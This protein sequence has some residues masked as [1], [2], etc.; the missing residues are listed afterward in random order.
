MKIAVLISGGVDSSVALRLLKDEGH[1][2]TAFYL[3][4][5]LED[6]L[7]Y[8]GECPWKE[9]LAYVRQICDEAKVPFEVINM[10]KE[11]WD[12]VVDYTIKEAKAGRTPN[13]DIFCNQRVKFGKFYDH[14]DLSY[15]KVATG[16]YAQV[17]SSAVSLQSSAE[18][19]ILK[20][21]PDTIK[22]Q[23][24]FLVH[25]DQKQLSRA[26]FPIGKYKKS[27]VRELANKYNLSNKD[28]KDSQGICF[29]GKVPF[30]EFIKHHLGEKPGDFVDIQSKKV[31]GQHDGYWFY[32][33]GQ[34]QGL[35]LSGGPW[36]VVDK[37]VKKN[38]VYLAQ[39]YEPELV[40]KENFE[41]S[42]LHWINEGLKI[43]DYGLSVKIRHGAAVHPCRLEVK[44]NKG[45]V[46][47]SEKV[48]GVAPGQ[49][50]VF[51]DGDVCLGCGMI[52]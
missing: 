27:E 39:G 46:E 12:N 14:I 18:S 3:K 42:N 31:V 20:K 16:H 48:H 33:I 44:G 23:T 10:Q 21:S 11:Y 47:L 2:L 41:V 19:F 15:E 8:L 49:F 28:R 13:P 22:D 29:L 38:V 32:T 43:K 24:Y 50:A 5:W 34:R 6:E 7:S 51:Y 40:Y 26:M 36:F 37:D 25:L 9:D 30:R 1:N 17:Q 4:I 45:K 35:G 52:V